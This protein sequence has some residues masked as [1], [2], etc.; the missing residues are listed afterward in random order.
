MSKASSIARTV[1]ITVILS[2]LLLAVSPAFPQM[3]QGSSISGRILLADKKAP[4]AGA[5]VKAA[6][7]ESKK[8]FESGPT[9]PNGS[10]E[11]AGLSKGNYDVAVQIGNGLYVVNKILNVQENESYALSLTLQEDP[12]AQEEQKNE[13]KPAETPPA[14]TE[15]QKDSKIGFWNNPLTAT[16]TLVGIAIVTGYAIDEVTKEEKRPSPF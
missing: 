8:I 16:L 6:E 2:F 13:E 4:V 9:A 15:E 14:T 11:I 1:S 10:Y 7:I 3:Q 12:K 5:I